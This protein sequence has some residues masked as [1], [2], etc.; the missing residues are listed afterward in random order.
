MRGYNKALRSI[1]VNAA[2][3]MFPAMAC[4]YFPSRDKFLKTYFAY[5]PKHEM[6]VL[7]VKPW[8]SAE[9]NEHILPLWRNR[10]YQCRQPAPAP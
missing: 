1:Q 7:V 2:R 3:E 4:D 10:Y 8:N 5:M 6:D 9:F